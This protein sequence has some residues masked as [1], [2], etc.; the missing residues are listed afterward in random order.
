MLLTITHD[1]LAFVNNPLILTYFL[2]KIECSSKQKFS[3]ECTRRWI[4]VNLLSVNCA[5][6]ED[7]EMK[8]AAAQATLREMIAV[9]C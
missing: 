2:S 3:A 4:N 7:S 1:T 5:H 8:V 6:K 9:D